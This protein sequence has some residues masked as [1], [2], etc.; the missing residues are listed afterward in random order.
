MN[1]LVLLQGQTYP[2][3]VGDATSGG[4]VDGGGGGWGKEGVGVTGHLQRVHA[5]DGQ[6]G[7]RCARGILRVP[8]THFRPMKKQEKSFDENVRHS[9]SHELSPVEWALFDILD[10]IF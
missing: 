9:F 10:S 4:E 7:E 1:C 5:L 6:D 8:A 3:C 2:G